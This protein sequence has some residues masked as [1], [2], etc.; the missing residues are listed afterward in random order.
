MDLDEIIPILTNYQQKTRFT[1][2]YIGAPVFIV[3]EA[4]TFSKLGALSVTRSDYSFLKEGKRKTTK[5]TEA[6]MKSPNNK[7][8]L[9][10]PRYSPPNPSP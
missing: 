6:V 5:E 10:T 7:A 9:V 1:L 8:A 2:H 3:T 4:A